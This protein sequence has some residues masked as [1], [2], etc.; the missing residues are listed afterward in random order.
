MNLLQEIRAKIKKTLDDRAA[1][2][3]ELKSI[4]DG[5]EERGDGDLTEEESQKFGEIRKE[6]ADLDEQ[7][8][9]YEAREKE[10]ADEDEARKKADEARKRYEPDPANPDKRTEPRVQVNEPS[11]YREGGGHSFFSDAFRAFGKRGN[12]DFAAAERLKKHQREMEVLGIEARNDP[13]QRDVGTGAFGGLVV[14]QYLVDDF[15]PVLRNGR[16][17]INALRSEPLPAE[18]MNLIIPRGETGVSVAPQATENA[19]VSETDLDYDNDLTIPVRTF[20]GQQDVSRQ[21]LERGT[22]GIDRLI[23]NDLV[24]AYAAAMD[25]SAIADDGTSGTHKGVLNA[26]GVN[27][28]T[29]TDASP[30][31][32]EIYPKLADAV[33]QIAGNRKMS[34]NLWVMH[35]RRWGWFLASLD[36]S[37]RPLIVPDAGQARNAMGDA[38]ANFGEGQLVG[39]LQGLPVLVDANV[40]TDLGG[41]TEDRII[42]LR[43]TDPIIWEEG[44]G[45]PKE[46][47]FEETAGGNLTVKLVVYGYSAFTAERY[48]N[49]VSVIAGTGLIA[50]TF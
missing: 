3:A 17:F 20:A 28:V 41:G 9:K 38:A 37:N 10:L 24:G 13:E 27:S 8:S 2:E 44:D 35:P 26:T 36:T 23:Y 7:R 25:A 11:T 45:M 22:P 18:G 15:A 30:T 46:L 14:P 5:A 4:V 48:A 43:S 33:Q 34:A 39:L 40:P 47:S 49:A 21:S 29:Y 32:A 12:T 31:V 42:G 1:K 16:A 6:I 50:P 19:A